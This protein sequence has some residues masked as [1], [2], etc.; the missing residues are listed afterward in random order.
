MSLLSVQSIDTFYNEVQA[1]HDVSIEVHEEEIVT[2]LGANG[3]GKSTLLR[4]ISGLIKPK[5]GEIF[6]QG[7]LISGLKPEAIARK[8][9]LHV[10]EGRQIFP[11]LTVYE[12]LE[13]ATTPWYQ[14]GNTSD[15]EFNKLLEEV[16]SLFPV[17]KSRQDQM[18]WSLSGGEQQMLAIG[19]ALMAK[20]KL[21]LLDEPS[22]GLAP[23]LVRNVFMT[24]KKINKRGTT[25][26]LVEQNAY[27]ALKIANRG[28]VLENGRVVLSD[29]AEKLAADPEVKKAYLG[30]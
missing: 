7:S 15:N 13:L 14:F 10:P 21:I 5:K 8:G 28:Y 3:A 16:Y 22:L 29:T 2:M 4:T 1:L 27:L 17:L 12:N 9:L 24:I 26:F 23:Q 30:G 11:G 25:I 18:G 20:P 19:R 6:F